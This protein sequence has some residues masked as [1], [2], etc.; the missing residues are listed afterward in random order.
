MDQRE[1]ELMMERARKVLPTKQ[2]T[3]AAPAAPEPGTPGLEVPEN[4]PVPP[5]GPGERRPDGT[6]YSQPPAQEPGLGDASGLDAVVGGGLKSVFE[7]K[8]FLFGDTLPEDR[9]PF[10][11]SVE[12]T[13]D[14]RRDQSMIDGFSAG[15]GQFAVGMIGLGKFGRAA[16]MLPWFGKGLTLADAGKKAKVA[17]ETAKAATV[18]AVAFD[19]MEER[20]SNLIQETPLANP[21]TD[22]L[23]ADPTDS[24]AE[25]RMKAA[26]ESIG[27]DAAIIGVF[28]GS[29]KVWKYLRKGDA[30][31]AS[32]AVTE[33]EALRDADLTAAQAADAAPPANMVELPDEIGDA[34]GLPGGSGGLGDT[35][36][37]AMGEGGGPV[38]DPASAPTEMGQ[39][40]PEGGLNA[41]A[42]QDA[43][44]GAPTAG[45]P[46]VP[47]EGAPDGAPV[48]GGAG[49]S[50]LPEPDMGGAPVQAGDPVNVRA[51]TPGVAEPLPGDPAAG[52]A[53]AASPVGAETVVPVGATPTTAA[54]ADGASLPN[55]RPRVRLADED[56]EAVLKGFEAD[57]AAIE[58]HGGWYQATEAGHVFGKGEGV[59]YARLNNP[60]EVDDF[61]ARL[62]DQ[63]EEQLDV[64]RGGK[65]LSDATLAR[66]S[67]RMS[68]LFNMNPAMV[69]GA[70]R[71]AGE[72][73]PRAVAM[74]ETSFL[75]ANRIF[76]DSFALA[77][78]IKAGDF[79]KY[80]TR[81]AALQELTKR[82]EL[83]ASAY[84]AGRAIVASSGR[85]VRRMRLQFKVDPEK[86]NALRSMPGAELVD[87]LVDTAGDP[88]KIA[89]V[90]NPSWW[91][92]GADGMTFLLVNNL[93]SG[94]KTQLI[95]IMSNGYMMGVRPLERMLGAIPEAVAGDAA[96]RNIVKSSLK[97]YAYMGQVLGESWRL[98][99]KAFL[100]NDSLL[101]PH[102][103]EMAQ[104]GQA[105]GASAQKAFQYKPWTNVGN[106]LHNTIAGSVRGS[107][108]AIG[109][110]TRTLG[111]VDEAVK[112]TVYRSK[113]MSDAYVEAAEQA[114]RMGLDAKAGK[115]YIRK[116]VTESVEASIDEFG[117]ATRAAPLREAMIATFQQELLPGTMGKTVQM[118][119]SRHPAMRLVLPFVRTPANVLRYGWKLT[120]G[121]NL[122]QTE[123]REMLKGVHGAEAQK[124]AYGQ[125]ALGS[126]YLGYGAYLV[127]QGTVTGGGPRDY[128]VKSEMMG[129][130]WQEYSIAH[131]NED[132]SVTYI[133]YNRMDPVAIPMGI[134]ADL[135]TV[136]AANDGEE[137]KGF[138]DTL[139][140]L[141]YALARQLTNKTYLL[142]LSTLMEAFEDPEKRGTAWMAQTAANFMPYAAMA[143]QLDT[144]PYLREA[145][146]MAD[147]LIDQTPGLNGKLPA[148]YDAW[149]DPRTRRTG[150]WSTVEDQLV[151]QEVT[152]LGIVNGSV[153][154]TPQPVHNGVDLRDVTLTDG[155]NAFEAYQRLAGQPHPK[156]PRLKDQIAKVM[157][158]K[159]YERAPDGEITVK[160]TKLWLLHD[161][162]AKYRAAALKRLKMDPIIRDAFGAKEKAVREHYHA[163]RGEPAPVKRQLAETGDAFGVDLGNTTGR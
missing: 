82:L 2:P 3:A 147:R 57:A 105:A 27:M 153:I 14:L 81:E 99:G 125:F 30:N 45:G 120:P 116:F 145:R 22:F 96:A 106:V 100:R 123:Y 46:G 107:V 38:V 117:R 44:G 151:D 54:A 137:P 23:A 28:T 154:T 6:A 68:T 79:S 37:P 67:D 55:P 60:A 71:K 91:S 127:S 98:A 40:A 34:G 161:P 93:V 21:I 162:V 5:E 39:A 13:V 90:A 163:L 56:T 11:A 152:R 131:Q 8:D 52:P 86:V 121:L 158:S 155:T 115:A 113:V 135:Y 7:T 10:R 102:N 132:G 64:M 144:D 59:P 110:P 104:A 49:P 26:L 126:M 77:N 80:G 78:L 24:R 160:G 94:P 140:A 133:P 150:L 139:G 114:V 134:I 29:A 128:K 9:S 111:L 92:R 157:Q 65:V 149:G 159:A 17:L 42:T 48:A 83:A 148:R 50:G 118:V 1:F 32:R 16:Q 19:P 73:A 4:A 20:L 146:G 143:R 72:E 87:L 63:A 112:Q 31:M 85:A 88:R 141:G 136:L 130:G 75:V 124:Q 109:L 76:N 89:K 70:I 122:L 41:T 119:V 108:A 95:N 101:A 36:G 18:G 84:G 15:I 66:T 142:S 156:L 74:M 33:L 43:L 97:Q 25:G 61:V 138:G 103:L 62:V 51:D 129:A 12:D 69:M 58:K 47:L 53:G 35:P